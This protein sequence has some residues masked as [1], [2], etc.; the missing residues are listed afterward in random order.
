MKVSIIVPFYN[1]R[2][3]IGACIDS[4]RGQLECDLEVILVD[5][6]GSDNTIDEAVRAVDGDNRFKIVV[7]QQNMGVAVARNSGIDNAS[8]DYIFFL[9]ADDMLASD[10]SIS[11][12][13][14]A[15]EGME[16]VTGNFIRSDNSVGNGRHNWTNVTNKLIDVKWLKDNELYFD[17]G[18][19]YDDISWALK[20]YTCAKKVAHVD[21]ETYYHNL[22]EGSVTRSHFSKAKVE[23]LIDMLTIINSYKKDSYVIEQI[24]YQTMFVLKNLMLGDFENHYKKEQYD[25]LSMLGVLSLKSD[26]SSLGKFSKKLYKV[27]CSWI[28]SSVLCS[29]YKRLKRC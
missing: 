7:H 2:A 10:L 16:V 6:C 28:L 26:G 15:C 23:S 20:A 27:R 12:L 17:K 24:V 14:D 22:R 8:G 21:A 19:I 29:I 25:R 11:K 1:D 18:L 13:L 5:D 4:I 9:D 3:Y